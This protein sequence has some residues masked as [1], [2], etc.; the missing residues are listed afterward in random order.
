MP[1]YLN[2]NVPS[3]IKKLRVACILDE[4]STHFFPYEC[5]MKE[6]SPGNWKQ[7]LE[8][9]Q[10]HLL[11][12]ESAW[13]GI[14]NEWYKKVHT[15][16]REL[17]GIID[18]CIMKGVPKVFW[19]KEDPI[20]LSTF[21]RC[22][23]FFDY[24]FTTDMDCIPLYKRLLKHDRISVLLFGAPVHNFDPIEKYQRKDTACF[25]G[26]YYGKREERKQDFHKIVEMLEKDWGLEIYDRN[27]YP[28]NPDYTF[29]DEMKKFIVGAGLPVTKMDLAYKG[30]KLGITLNIVKHSSTM[31]ARRAFELMSSNTVMLSNP[32]LGL[33]NLFGDLI[34]FCEDSEICSKQLHMLRENEDLY[35][36]LRLRGLRKV[37]L[38]HTYRHRMRQIYRTVFGAGA[39][40]EYASV[41]VV[42]Q[43][44]DQDEAARMV[45]LFEKQS[46]IDMSLTIIAPDGVHFD[47]P[48]IS[49][50]P[51]SYADVPFKDYLSGEW[52]AF[53]DA[54]HYYGEHYIT[55]MLTAL[56]YADVSVIGKSD[57]FCNNNGDIEKLR[58]H[59]TYVYVDE[60]MSDRCVIAR[61]IAA[62]MTMQM[63]Q[64]N[65]MLENIIGLAV[66]E[67]GFCANYS[68]AACGNVDDLH[69]DEGYSMKQILN[70]T[71]QL[72]NDRYWVSDH[73]FNN[74]DIYSV[75]SEKQINAAVNMLHNAVT[76]RM[77]APDA[78]TEVFL[79]D[80]LS[81]DKLSKKDIVS[82]YIDGKVGGSAS[83]V[84]VFFDAEGIAYEILYGVP[85]HSITHISIPENTVRFSLAVR[86]MKDT[87]WAM[88]KEII[89]NPEICGPIPLEEA[90]D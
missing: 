59:G 17:L 24:V 90:H 10:P 72:Q 28:G 9:F 67:Y 1:Y 20:H 77:A 34:L 46:Y 29:P 80:Q 31:E 11:F 88:I 51:L 18:W 64:N 61:H 56:E 57:H 75:L 44:S 86:F 6:L 2:Q 36:K 16:S 15:C 4:L 68:E 63:L 70:R 53:F 12:V 3:D 76:V 62:G 66:D 82:I 54:Q 22:A 84:A 87:G 55:D 39:L 85:V 19:N 30:Y 8:E 52:V 37:L 58:V 40:K 47:A 78:N 42:T 49:V 14:R 41:S 81:V 33:K 13:H 79:T 50:L 73:I 71:A 74:Q 45:S 5:I 89:I 69:V 43:V 23:S 65:K 32:C 38:Q 26:S 21:L 60:M 27:V 7:E 83:V 35:N 48:G 25:A